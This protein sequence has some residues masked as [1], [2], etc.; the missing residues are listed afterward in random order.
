MRTIP[1][2]AVQTQAVREL[3]AP[4]RPEDRQAN[5]FFFGCNRAG[6]SPQSPRLS[7]P[8]RRRRPSR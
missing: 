1:L 4:Y 5:L 3:Y 7:P 2:L 6:F 8:L